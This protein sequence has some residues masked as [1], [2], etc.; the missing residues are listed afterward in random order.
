MDIDDEPSP[1]QLERLI[2]SSS[3]FDR[4]RGDE[5]YH[6]EDA[7]RKLD[8][9]TEW[10]SETGCSVGPLQDLLALVPED[11]PLSLSTLQ[12]PC[13]PRLEGEYILLP[14]SGTIPVRLSVLMSPR[15]G[16]PILIHNIPGKGLGILATRRIPAGSI[17]LSDPYVLSI[18]EPAEDPSADQHASHMAELV[19]P[20]LVKQYLQLPMDVRRQ[21]ASL[22][23][24]IEPA[25]RQW[26]RGCLCR[27]GVELDEEGL[28][29]TTRLYFTF[30][31]NEFWRTEA[32]RRG[33]ERI[34]RLF[35]VTS[36]INHSC[37]PNT[38]SRQTTDGYKVVTASR[39]IEEGEE[40]TLK[41]LD[42]YRFTRRAWQAETQRM[43][44][45]VCDCRGCGSKVDK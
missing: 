34:R 21:L 35:L 25:S 26:L 14:T 16:K 31:T 9:G 29:F 3:D 17:I 8:T 32:G 13:V 7:S 6:H 20:Q 44:G 43:W 41:Y 5:H 40:I 12:Q 37:C 4:G 22:H 24:N 19:L 38:T 45:F 10:A 42:H 18:R 36:R 33:K 23:A 2:S 1:A 15:V 28:K 39:D 30:S 27:A 11:D